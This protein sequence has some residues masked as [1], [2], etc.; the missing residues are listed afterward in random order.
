MVASTSMEL[1]RGLAF[2]E[3]QN[4]VLPKNLSKRDIKVGLSLSFLCREASFRI[5]EPSTW[6]YVP[7]TM[8]AWGS[9]SN[10]LP[11]CAAY[12]KKSID[13]M[14]KELGI[15]AG[16]DVTK[17]VAFQYPF[18]IS[19]AG[20][21][22]EARPFTTEQQCAWLKKYMAHCH[23]EGR[24][25][26]APATTTPDKPSLSPLHP[27][28]QAQSISA[29][30]KAELSQSSSFLAPKI[31][32]SSES[33]ATDGA[34]RDPEYRNQDR[35][36]VEDMRQCARDMRRSTSTTAKALRETIPTQQSTALVGPSKAVPS[37]RRTFAPWIH[38]SDHSFSVPIKPTMKNQGTQTWA[39]TEP[40]PKQEGSTRLVVVI[41]GFQEP[42]TADT[43]AAMQQAMDILSQ[44]MDNMRSQPDSDASVV[45][46]N[47]NMSTPVQQ[48]ASVANGTNTTVEAQAAVSRQ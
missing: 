38:P 2:S 14:F 28:Q 39:V 4:T 7:H 29:T 8:I 24:V 9:S 33:S 35:R 22:S 1:N 23:E 10:Q 25:D 44:T 31:C 18:N 13:K 42:S 27:P 12:E 20:E 34:T 19:E 16:S 5:E 17:M 32:Q 21:L 6:Y 46:S 47:S 30:D 3:P 26:E 45:I 36:S 37:T 43:R 11:A 15:V 41:V 48:D 40:A